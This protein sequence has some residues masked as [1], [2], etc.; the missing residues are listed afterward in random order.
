MPP[1][2]V[3]VKAFCQRHNSALSPIDDEALRFFV[4]LAEITAQLQ[5]P[6]TSRLHD[7]RTFNGHDLERWCSALRA[8]SPIFRCR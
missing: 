7:F 3:T 5:A 1:S 2:A 4:S 8:Y 6:Q